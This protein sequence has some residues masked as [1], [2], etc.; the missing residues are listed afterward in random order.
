M[1]RYFVFFLLAMTAVP[2]AAQEPEVKIYTKPLTEVLKQ[3][4]E[5]YGVQLIY[6]EKNV[7]NRLVH[8][9]DWRF[10]AGLEATLDNILKPQELRWDKKPDG[11]YEIKKWEYFRKPF[12][13]GRIHLEQL[14]AS[15]GGLTG[16][17]K[18]KTLLR[19]N[20]LRQMKLL[21]FP[22]LTP[23]APIVTNKRIYDGYSVENVALEVLPGVYLSGSLYKP[24]KKSRKYPAMLSPHGHFYNKI[25][26]MILNERGRYRED[27]Q[28]RC[29]VLAQMGAYVFSYDMFG[30]GESDLQF[31]HKEN[32]RT[33]LA[34][35]MQT[36]NSMRVI[37]FLCSLP[38][39]DQSRI[40]IT[41]ASGGGTQTLLAAAL[42]DRI[43]LS[44]P[45]VMTSS[46]F[47]GGCPCESGLP[48]HIV[49]HGI[50]SNN[51]EIAAMMAPKPQLL[52]S[53]GKDWTVTTPD[54][55]MPYLKKVYALFNKE[56]EV[57]NV[58][59]PDDDHDYGIN[60]RLPMYHFVAQHFKMDI[61]RVCDKNGTI[62]ESRVTIEPAVK[63]L[64]FGAE[65][66]LP[67]N[68]VKEADRVWEI[69][70]SLQQ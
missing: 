51:A 31:P 22:K 16:W 43:S 40:G 27:Q 56:N 7:Q 69:I 20:I 66:Q 33:G 54:I 32:H 36:W 15:Y 17:E 52:I 65:R 63:M 48:I 2:L 8:Y 28:Y 12:E 39:V 60:K 37:D 46:H 61:S 67:E 10:Y 3:V 34:L 14:W 9:A 53:D 55:E 1:R 41:G 18:R 68:A 21:P 13:E 5:R 35:T 38:E 26:K 44:I 30:W 29:A 49:P 59:L 58:H 42:D 19:D 23:L 64:V 24:T 70:R 47:F 4:E 50:N 6:E 11:T 62:D 45:V 57:Q 25:D